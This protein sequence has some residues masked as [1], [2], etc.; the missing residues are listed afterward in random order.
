LQRPG[1]LE[2]LRGIPLSRPLADSRFKSSKSWQCG[3]SLDHVERDFADLLRCRRRRDDSSTVGQHYL[4]YVLRVIRAQH[5]ADPP[6]ERMPNQV[7]RLQ[8]HAIQIM[9]DETGI[10]WHA[11][12]FRWDGTAPESRQIN[13][14]QAVTL[15]S[16]TLRHHPHTFDPPTPAM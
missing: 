6:A 14:M 9:C 7:N 13:H 5:N 12:H 3:N 11:P 1:V 2:I 15:R 16:E 4:I 8:V 10:F